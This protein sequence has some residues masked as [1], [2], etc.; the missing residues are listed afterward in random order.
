MSVKSLKPVLQE[1]HS[2]LSLCQVSQDSHM[3]QASH[4]GLPGSQKVKIPGLHQASP[5]LILRLLTL[6][7]PETSP[8]SSPAW[9]RGLHTIAGEHRPV[10]C[11]C[12]AKGRRGLNGGR[13][14]ICFQIAGS[15]R[16]KKLTCSLP[17]HPLPALR[18]PALPPVRWPEKLQEVLSLAFCTFPGGGRKRKGTPISRGVLCAKPRAGHF[19][20]LRHEILPLQCP[21]TLGYR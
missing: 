17:Q 13:E 18:P 2:L 1:H 14:G 12:F 10:S 6:C 16:G 7:V 3:P 19:P 20:P 11:H 5:H 8:G 21:V 4:L 9:P 15:Q